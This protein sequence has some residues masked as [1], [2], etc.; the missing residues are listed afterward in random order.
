MATYFYNPGY[1]YD[2]PEGKV[3]QIG[4]IAE[5]IDEIFPM[6][7]TYD[8]IGQPEAWNVNK[9]L[10]PILEVVKENDRRIEE[11]ESWK[12]E[13]IAEIAAMK[14]AQKGAQLC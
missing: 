7:C 5:D 4:F 1:C 10:P 8:D 6:A 14:A 12:M 3:L 9:L 13:I 2:D 11:L